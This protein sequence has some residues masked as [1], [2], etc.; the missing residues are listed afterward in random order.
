MKPITENKK[1]IIEFKLITGQDMIEDIKKLFLEYS[2]S[3]EMEL[4][5]Q[6]FEEEFNALPG[7]YG[8]PNGV[9]ILVLVDGKAAGCIALRKISGDICEMKRLYLRDNYRGLGIGKKLIAMLIEEA[10]KLKYNYIRLDTI[11]SLK[12]AQRLYAAFGFYEIEPYT[13]NPIEGAKF[14]ELKL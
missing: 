8:P 13:H 11:P 12:A 6:N 7:K 4:T 1:Q 10:K 14:L 9:L 2:Q 5:F 3:L